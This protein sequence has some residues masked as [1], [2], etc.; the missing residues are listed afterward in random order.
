MELKAAVISIVVGQGLNQEKTS[1]NLRPI[2][3]SR[4]TYGSIRGVNRKK[5]RYK[6]WQVSGGEV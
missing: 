3:D 6:C 4:E 1:R 2:I 5:L